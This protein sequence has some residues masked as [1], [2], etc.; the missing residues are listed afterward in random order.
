M[1]FLRRRDLFM[2]DR[3]NTDMPAHRTYRRLELQVPG[4]NGVGAP[5][6]ACHPGERARN[7]AKRSV[8]RI[9]PL[10]HQW[11]IA[12]LRHSAGIAADGAIRF[13]AWVGTYRSASQ[14]A[15]AAEA[16]YADLSRLSEAELTRRGLTRDDVHKLV[17]GRLVG[18][19]PGAFA[20]GDHLSHPAGCVSGPSL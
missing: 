17:L 8:S 19:S 11:V 12:E 3:A 2:H 20:R 4:A 7:L 16:L 13:T 10:L 5:R 9:L 18:C 6:D 1:H 15:F 14:E